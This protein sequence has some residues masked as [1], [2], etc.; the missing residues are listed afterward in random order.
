CARHSCAR[1]PR[2]LPSLQSGQRSVPNWR[3]S[4]PTSFAGGSPSTASALW[5]APVSTPE[6]ATVFLVR[7]KRTT[8]VVEYAT[9]SVEARDATSALERAEDEALDLDESAWT[10]DDLTESDPRNGGIEALE[11]EDELP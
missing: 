9:V 6:R 2:S 11:V 1:S 10:T 3:R 5:E 7:V 8:E 4:R